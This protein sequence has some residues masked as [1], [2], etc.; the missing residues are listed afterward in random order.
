MHVIQNRALVVKTRKPERITATI[1]KS[2]VIGTKGD[3]SAVMVY[4]GLEEVQVLKNLGMKGVPSPIMYRYN[5]PGMFKPFEHQKVTSE[6]L[7]LH[8]R[9]YVFNDP[10]TGKTAS[11]AWAADY[12]MKLSF[13]RRV[14]IICPMSIMSAAWRADL[15][16]TLMHRRVDIAHGDRRKRA[17][18]IQSDAEFVIIN[19]DGVEI[20][21]EELRQAQFDLV[22]V[23]EANALKIH[24]TKRWKAINSLLT[25]STWLWMMTGT[26]ASQS[27]TDAYGLARM[28][29]PSSVPHNFYSFRDKVMWKVTT[30]RWVPK[31]NAQEVVR[32]VLQPAIRFTKD[33]CLDLPEL[34][35]TDRDIPLTPQ[36]KKYYDFMKER[37]IME[38]AGETVTA[39]NAAT[40]LNK[41]LQVSSGAVYTDDGKTVEFDIKTRYEELK[42]TI[43]QSTHKVLVFAPYRHAI[44][45]LEER[46]IKDGYKVAVIHGGVSANQR[47]EIFQS[48]QTTPDPHVL[49]IQPAAASH[50]VT[51]H[52]ANTVVW[53]GPVTSAETYTQA[54]ARVHR[55][56]QKNP[57]LVVHLIGSPVER[58]VYKALREK[59]EFSSVLLDLYKEAIDE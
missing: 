47:T 33:E 31:E 42:D 57:C 10:G 24:T 26:P 34:L 28:L 7:T 55:A 4:F 22:V 52:A 11:I 23:D 1:P 29:S 51:L 36:Q 15:F 21:Q 25:P 19:Y 14:L 50:G 18:V 41:L 46:L 38:A 53:W 2:K 59:V 16:K 54:N 56:G 20:V 8:R 5:W 44:G 37:F 17:A 13:L 48:F 9:G 40:N 49:I 3:V 58:R 32:Q 12:L 27:P 43:D 35:Y 39:V 30:F 6:F 45:V